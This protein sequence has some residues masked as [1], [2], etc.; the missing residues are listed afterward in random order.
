MAVRLPGPA[1]IETSDG[2]G[3]SCD[4]GAD[5]GPTLHA[6]VERIAVDELHYLVL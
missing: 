1:D 6:I 3:H 4:V 2:S 5:V